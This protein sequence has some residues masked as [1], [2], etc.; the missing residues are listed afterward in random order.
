[1][2]LRNSK[3]VAIMRLQF[4]GL[5]PGAGAD[6]DRV[7]MILIAPPG[8]NTARAV[9]RDLRL[10]A[11]GIQQSYAEVGVRGGQHPLDAIGADAVVTIAN[12]TGEGVN[13][14]GRMGKIDDQE[15]VAAGG[16]FNERNAG[17]IRVLRGL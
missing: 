10:G 6:H 1:M 11:I 12:A 5:Q 17:H 4:A 7:A 8:R 16:R 14:A 9:A 15:I 3:L 2:E 13:V